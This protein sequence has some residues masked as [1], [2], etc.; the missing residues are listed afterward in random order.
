MAQKKQNQ[1]DSLLL[2][3]QIIADCFEDDKMDFLLNTVNDEPVFIACNL[4]TGQKTLFS[5]IIYILPAGTTAFPVN[6]YSYISSDNLEGNAPHIRN[7]KMDTGEILNKVINIFQKHREFEAELNAVITEGG[8][9]TDLCQVGNEFFKNPMYVHDNMFC[10]VAIPEYVQGMREFDHDSETGKYYI[11]LWLINDFKFDEEYKKTMYTRSATLWTNEQFPRNNSAVYANIFDGTYYM[12][13]LLLEELKTPIKK[14]QFALLDYFA[15]YVRYIMIR[16]SVSQQSAGL[17]FESTFRD[18]ILSDTVKDADLDKFL[19]IM[20]WNESDLY[21]CVKLVS[22][23]GHESLQSSRSIKGKYSGLFHDSYSFYC[24]NEFCIIINVE[25]TNLATDEISAKLAPSVREGCLYCGI[26]NRFRHIKYIAEGFKQADAA[27]N[28]L[29]AE[30]GNWI[31]SFHSSAVDYLIKKS[32]D[33]LSARVYVPTGLFNLMRYDSLHG[34]DYYKTLKLYLINE[35][36]ITRVSEQLSI[37]RTTLLYRL[38]KIEEL[39]SY[40][41]D[42]EA[43]RLYLLVSFKV[44]EDYNL[45]VKESE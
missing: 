16:D 45:K 17:D 15:G 28:A 10:I 11:P 20:S 18:M 27:I 32:L 36:N 41:L 14:G 34:T 8:S 4:Y 29:G 39:L 5:D 33:G 25:N 37:H 12:G 40:D 38:G 43:S 23:D 30:S 35:R 3:V 26:S 2:S 31:A 19:N 1:L 44:I 42:D 24:G 22:Q 13:R 9:L 21:V 7:I 6:R